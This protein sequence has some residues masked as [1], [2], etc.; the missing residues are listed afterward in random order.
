MKRLAM[1]MMVLVM[2]V[3]LISAP[4]WA[5][6]PENAFVNFGV[7]GAA[8]ALNHMIVPDDVTISSGGIVNFAIVSGV[9][10]GA[11]DGAGFHQVTV[12][13]VAEGT[14]LSSIAAQIRPGANYNI[15][16]KDGALVLQ[17]TAGSPRVDSDPSG[18]RV[19][20]EAEPSS[21]PRTVGVYFADPGT[22]LVICNVRAH[23]DDGMI[24]IVTVKK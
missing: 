22:Y 20:I 13:R 9:G 7:P 2:A 16:D 21:T 15:V 8:G 19:F 3:M 10:P 12:Y 11:T 1:A 24:A 6:N 18:L 4:A 5:K 23:L 17:V 14:K